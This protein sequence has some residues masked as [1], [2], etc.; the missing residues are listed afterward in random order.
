MSGSRPSSTPGR[1]SGRPPARSPSVRLCV[2]WGCEEAL[3]PGSRADRM[4]CSP[5]CQRRVATARKRSRERR[6]NGTAPTRTDMLLVSLGLDDDDSPVPGLTGTRGRDYATSVERVMNNTRP[7]EVFKRTDIHSAVGGDGFERFANGPWPQDIAEGHRTQT[8]AALHF[9]VSQPTIAGWMSLHSAALR[10]NVNAVRW[11]ADHGAQNLREYALSSFRNFTEVFFPDDLVPDFHEEWDGEITGALDDGRRTMLL[12]PQR[13]GK[14]SFMIRQCLYRIARDPNIRII[15]VGKTQDL[16]R[17]AVGVIRQYL[18]NDP[19][20]AE[21][22]LPPDT[23]FR[24]PSRRGLPWTNDEFVVGTRT[25]I[26]K[27]P[28]MVAIGIGGSILGRDADLIVIDDPIDRKS[29]LSPTEREKVREWFFSDFSSR[30]EEHTGVIYI[31]SR[32]HKEDLC[33]SI[34]S[35]NASSMASGGEPDWKVMVYRAHAMSCSR[36]LI[37]HPDDPDD[38]DND[39]I[40]WPEVRSARW[41]AEQQRNNPEHFQRNYMNNPSS[42]AFKPVKADDIERSYA[43]DEWLSVNESSPM[44]RK[45]HPHP[46]SFG[47]PHFDTRIVASVDPA[48]AKKNAAVLWSYTTSP[49]MMPTDPYDP[50]SRVVA[51]PVRAIVTYDEPRP[52]SPGVVDLL[53]EWTDTYRVT[54]WVFETNYFADQIAND[55]DINDFKARYGLKFHTHYTGRHNKHDERAGLLAMLSSMGSVPPQILLPGATTQS[56]QNMQRFVTQMLNYDPEATHYASGQRRALDDDLLMAAWFGWYWIERQTRFRST[57][58]VFE[59]GSGGTAFAP[60]YWNHAPW[61]DLA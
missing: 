29:S 6:E 45:E 31:G 52:G 33:A 37:D 34:I 54:D 53:E 22:L 3:P 58:V 4:F 41:L 13:H 61:K 24:P 10:H 51:T 42:D 57:D 12:A 35:S 28:T 25:R 5:Q 39:C 44:H 26:L 15:V 30:I 19:Q 18:E 7:P 11:A 32:Q 46:R 23:G 59:Y 49:V 40:L 16:A 8:E 60:S 50:S 2:A 20:F 21:V 27:S 56:K 47:E 48:V 55:R 14:T 1:A 38:P 17:K 9:E 36:D 43:Y